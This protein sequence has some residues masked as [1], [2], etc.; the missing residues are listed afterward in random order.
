LLILPLVENSF[1][2]GASNQLEGGWIHIDI[3]VRDNTLLIKVE[4]NKVDFDKGHRP[5]GIGL[6]NARKRLNHLYPN[7]HSL[8]LF[9]GEDTFLAVLKISLNNEPVPETVL[10]ESSENQ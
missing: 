3:D 7:R 1:K 2:H 5:S 9:D 10:E 4:N 8:Q 6:E